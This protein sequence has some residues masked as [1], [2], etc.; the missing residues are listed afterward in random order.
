MKHEFIC[1]QCQQNKVH[2]SEVSTGYG[3]NSKDEKICFECCGV[4]DAAELKQLQPKQKAVQYWDGKNITNWAASL[5]INPYAVTH[6]SHN[7]AG[8][9]TD[10]YFRF[11]GRKFHAVQDGNFSQIA[12]INVLKS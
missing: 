7:M 5:V 12:Y 2:E 6:G 4:N 8:K 1:S 10:V 11:E 9:R 3:Y